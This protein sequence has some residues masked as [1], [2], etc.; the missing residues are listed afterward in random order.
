MLLTNEGILRRSRTRHPERGPFP[1]QYNGWEFDILGMKRFKLRP[2]TDHQGWMYICDAGPFWQC[3]FIKAINPEQWPEPIVSE[4]EYALILKGKENREN[5]KL[6]AD[7]MK[8]NA[9]E[10]E[11]LARAMT[12][13]N[14]GFITAGIRLKRNQWFGPGQAASAW[15]NQQPD[16]PR[17]EVWTSKPE[18]ILA[19][20]QDI[21]RKTYYGGW[22]EIM[23]HGIIPDVTWE[24]DINSAYPYIIANL[25]C[26]LH[27]K[28][29]TGKSKMTGHY[30]T[31]MH[32]KYEGSDPYIGGMPHRMED[33]GILRPNNGEGW[34]WEHEIQA[35]IDAGLIDKVKVYESYTYHP[36][37]C[38]PPLRALATLYNWRLS[39]GKNSPQGKGAKLLYNSA[40]GKFAQ[41]IGHP[42]FGNAIYASLIT[43]GCRTQILSAIASHP[44]K[45]AAVAMV[46]TD[47]IY[48]LARHPGLELSKTKLGAWDEGQKHDLTLFKPGVYWDKKTLDTIADGG[49]AAFKSRGVDAKAFAKQLSNLD[50]HFRQWPDSYP[51]TGDDTTDRTAADFPRLDIQSGFAMVSC[52]QALQRNKWSTAGSIYDRTSQEDSLPSNKRDFGYFEPGRRIY[53]STPYKGFPKESVEYDRLFG[54]VSVSDM[55]EQDKEALGITPDGYTIDIINELLY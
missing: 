12:R 10:N 53:R 22:F 26:L 9:L 25:P 2:L 27:G 54:N 19:K 18:S 42:L 14:E 35:S 20:M 24:Y 48:M 33:G 41:S 46:A 16:M 44:D 36:C 50:N 52:R 55:R 21:A 28:W 15:I 1:V 39:I 38:P 34:Y 30:Y 32:V 5:A 29:T 3:S 13:L 49:A 47:G 40:Y 37:S 43:A 17:S 45:S 11:V 7:M 51:A 4:D 6:N 31:M 23:C 8:Y